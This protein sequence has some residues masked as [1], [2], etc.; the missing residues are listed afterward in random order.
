MMNERAEEN[1]MREPL[2]KTHTRWKMA[3]GRFAS[4][5]QLKNWFEEQEEKNTAQKTERECKIAWKIFENE[6]RR[7]ESWSY[8]SRWGEWMH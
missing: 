8:F 4:V 7:Q 1:V 5:F 2:H 6:G 3:E